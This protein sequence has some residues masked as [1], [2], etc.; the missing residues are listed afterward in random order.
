M[1]SKTAQRILFTSL[2]LF[3][4]HG[5]SA[6]TSVDIAM[7]L[8]I[9]P[10]NLYYHF[11]G[12]EVIVLAL[13]EL[14][15][16]QMH[17]LLI[18]PQQTLELDEFFYFL[19]LLLDVNLTFRFLYRNPVDLLEK[20]PGLVKPFRLLLKQQDQ[21]LEDCLNQFIGQGLLSLEPS[22]VPL[23]LQ[24]LGLV[25]SQ[26][27]NYALLKAQELDAQAFEQQCMRNMLFLLRPYMQIEP[28]A[29]QD[30]QQTVRSGQREQ[31]RE[32]AE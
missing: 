30:F 27:G 23:M 11:K 6:V 32:H 5:E 16:E 4:T 15:R 25:F 22:D 20:Y 29:W 9:S 8:D 17:P 2:E 26:A 21:R 3:N 18:A 19:H 24:Q 12:K 1:A 28:G 31:N 7:E 13:F 10:G 14:Y